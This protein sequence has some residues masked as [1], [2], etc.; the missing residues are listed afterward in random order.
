MAEPTQPPSDL[1]FPPEYAE[2][3]ARIVT[4]W[5]SLE[6]G[7]NQTIWALANTPQAYGACITSQLTSL[8]TRLSAL[9]AL[10]KV[11]K[12]SEK[13]ISRVN[14]F[15]DDAR[16]PNELR[17]R[18]IH[19][20]WLNSFEIPSILGRLEITAPK[21]LT[22]AAKPITTDAL[23]EELRRIKAAT[24]AFYLIKDA[25]LAELPSLPDRHASE[26]NPI[27]T[28]PTDQ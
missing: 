7:I 1:V 18:V 27:T 9:L 22:I 20:P 11:R 16:A 2:L 21:K 14:K 3:I 5:S 24:D 8:H 15:A 25:I 13:L 12:C 26:L 6:Y 17:N 23:K 4:N 10:M 19:D 28:L